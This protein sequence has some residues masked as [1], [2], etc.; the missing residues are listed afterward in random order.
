MQ[1]GGYLGG[2]G[3]T[4]A[5]A[6]GGAEAGASTFGSVLPPL[7]LAL[8]AAYTGKKSLDAWKAGEGEGF[9]GGIKAAWK[10]EG[11]LKFVPLLG[12]APLIA[13]G[14]AGLLGHKSTRQVAQE[15]TKSLMG[16]GQNDPIWQ[17]YVQG[18][19]QQYNA[20]PPDPS[21]PFAGQY[22]TFDEYKKAGLQAGDLTGVYGNLKAFGPDWAK[23][24]DQQRQAVTQGLINENLYQSKKGEV[25]ITDEDRARQIRDQILNPQLQ[26]LQQPQQQ[27]QPLQNNAYNRAVIKQN[28][29]F[30][31]KLLGALAR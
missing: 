12:Q 5:A 22:A 27:P 24:S 7:A 31:S 11:P 16:Q 1:S 10:E 20:P 8:A 9:G 2:E 28:T 30:G 23:L 18:M 13:G 4:T 14:L 19:R 15:H 6:S 17:N 25:V 3:A 26:Q 29:Q 21:K